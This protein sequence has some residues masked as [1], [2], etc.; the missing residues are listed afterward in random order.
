M[1]PDSVGQ[2]AKIILGKHSGRA[3]FKDALDKLE[4]I[5]DDDAFNNAFD[6]FK[7]IADRKGEIVENELRAIVG[8]VET[9]ND[10]AKLISVSVNSKD[11][12]ASASVTRVSKPFLI[13]SVKPPHRTTCSP[14]K[15]VSVSSL[16]VVLKIPALP[17][18]I[19]DAYDIATFSVFPEASLWTA[20]RHGIPLPSA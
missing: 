14:N 1:S 13:N 4:I 20:T 6:T 5:L 17:P 10:A 8:Q 19:A 16:N 3:G 11:E 9:K 7:K 12:F 15:S 2:E 18:P